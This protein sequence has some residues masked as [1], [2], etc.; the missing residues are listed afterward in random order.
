MP[1][2]ISAIDFGD[3]V[4]R[5]F[6]GSGGSGI[7]AVTYNGVSQTESSG[8]VAI[9]GETNFLTETTWTTIQSILQ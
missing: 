8:T 7:S 3:G 5:Q 4:Q 9:D 6:R 1:D 2:Y